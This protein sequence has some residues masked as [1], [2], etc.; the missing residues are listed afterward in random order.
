MVLVEQLFALN[1]CCGD[2]G[3]AQLQ[4]GF[5]HWVTKQAASL[6]SRSLL[7]R[8]YFVMVQSALLSRCFCLCNYW[9]FC[10]LPQTE[11]IVS[12]AKCFLG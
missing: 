10:F 11:V 1:R 6:L 7:L 2:D 9:N 8:C 4:R 3:V 5:R 12:A